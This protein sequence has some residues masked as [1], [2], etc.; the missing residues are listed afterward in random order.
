MNAKPHQDSQYADVVTWGTDLDVALGPYI[1]CDSELTMAHV[2]GPSATIFHVPK[3]LINTR[4]YYA[5]STVAG[6]GTIE[7]G[8]DVRWKSSYKA[9]AYDP[10]TQQFCLQDTFNVYSYPVADLFVNFRIKN[11]CMFFKFSHLNEGLPAPG[12]FVTPFYPGQKRT[13]DIGINWS[14]FD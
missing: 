3:F 12:Y 5:D 1:H 7:A 8:V 13:F 14:F 11:W 9:D 6:N 4:L 10:V 2:L